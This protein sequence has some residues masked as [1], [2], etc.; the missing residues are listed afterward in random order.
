MTGQRIGAY[1][2]FGALDH[3][4]DTVIQGYRKIEATHC[5]CKSYCILLSSVICPIQGR[6]FKLSGNKNVSKWHSHGVQYF[7][8]FIILNVL[9]QHQFWKSELHLEW[10]GRRATVQKKFKV[11]EILLPAQNH[12]YQSFS[13][14]TPTAIQIFT[15]TSLQ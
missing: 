6:F 7:Y 15:A 8:T 5:A 14:F 2:F 13:H 9:S 4:S 3:P 12:L 11:S 1:V 10:R